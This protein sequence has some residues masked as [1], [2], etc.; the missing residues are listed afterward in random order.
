MLIVIFA[1]CFLLLCNWFQ[2]TSFVYALSHPKK[3]VS[4][5]HDAW[6]TK[7]I[8]GKTGINITEF[9]FFETKKLFGMMPST[10]PLKPKMILSRGIYEAFN[11]DE[12]EWVL[13]HEIGHYTL[14]HGIKLGIAQ[15]SLLFF[16]LYTIYDIKSKIVAVFLSLLL[17][18]LYIQFHKYIELEADTYSISRTSNP[19][20]VISAQEKLVKFN[21]INEKSIVSRYFKS[22]VLPSQRIAMASARIKKESL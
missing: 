11:K 12:L 19:R 22:Q 13:L 8:L 1:T 17:G 21:G 6:M 4:Y 10:F 3:R 7:T 16:G 18:F 14:M 9:T 2:I 15:F 5:V 20:G